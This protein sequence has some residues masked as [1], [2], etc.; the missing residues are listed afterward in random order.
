MRGLDLFSGIGG[1]SLALEPWVRS[2]AYCEQDP[3]AQRVLLTRQAKGQIERA[4]IWGDVRTLSGSILPEPP[5]IIFGGF[6]C[7]DLSC[8][9]RGAGLAGERSGL[10]FEIVR[11][12]KE[13]CAPLVFLENVPAIRT[14]GLRQVVGAFTQMGYD[15]RWTCVSASSVGAPHKRERWFFLAYS[16]RNLFGHESRRSSGTDWQGETQPRDNGSAQS[17]ANASSSRLS[18]RRSTDFGESTAQISGGLVNESQRCSFE[19][20]D[21][22]GLRRE[23][24]RDELGFEQSELGGSDTPREFPDPTRERGEPWSWRRGQP[25]TGPTHPF[26]DDWWAVEPDV[27]RVAHGIP[28]RVDRLRCLGNSVVPLQVRVA[29]ET[30]LGVGAK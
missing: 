13:T 22:A 8:A 24:P 1:I 29:F 10:F 16:E 2:I 5:D 7:Q 6:P 12:A 18:R 14:R 21:P 23:L 19:I 11:L 4:P 27:G 25:T 15:C 17:L 3:Y 26:A 30:L 20:S 9:G 28:S